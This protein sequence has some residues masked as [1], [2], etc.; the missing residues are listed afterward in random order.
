MLKKIDNNP[1]VSSKVGEENLKARIGEGIIIKF[2][3]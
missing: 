1:V 2:E 3:S